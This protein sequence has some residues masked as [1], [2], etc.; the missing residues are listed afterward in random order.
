MT[1]NRVEPE[2]LELVGRA[3][4]GDTEAF[5]EL[6]RRHQQGLFSYL[7]RMTGNRAVAE[8]LVQ[9][10]FIKAWRGIAGFGGRSGFKTWLYRIGINLAINYRTR[11]KPTTGLD[12]QLP[13]ASTSEPEAVYRQRRREALVQEALSRL[14][15]DQRTALVLSAFE[16][17]SYSEI[18][19]VMGRSSRAVDSLLFRA[20]SNLRR[21]LQPARSRGLL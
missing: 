14:P 21:L 15:P 18:G 10:A 7:Y 2:D 19:A 16:R 1:E 6:V 20:K 8:E 3:Q 4:T 17:M 11:A 5:E 12:E 13:A 9:Q